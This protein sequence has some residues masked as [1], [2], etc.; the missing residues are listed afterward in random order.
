[1]SSILALLLI[2]FCGVAVKATN[3]TGD[4]T[5]LANWP[6]CAQACIP[7][8]LAPPTSCESLSNLTCVCQNPAFT[9]AL[10]GCEQTTCSTEELK[11]IQDLSVPL[12]APV[13]GQPAS[14][15]SAVSSYLVTASLTAP[16]IPTY[17]AGLTAATAADTI[18]ATAT[19]EPDIGNPADILSFPLCAV[20]AL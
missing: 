12:C 16:G 2:S 19:P 1:M 3:T 4:P 8:G 15:F 13:G 10:V 7:I 18:L 14:V 5:D 9:L 11:Q 6:P 17:P 20:S